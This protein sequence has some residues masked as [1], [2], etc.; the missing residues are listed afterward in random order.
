MGWQHVVLRLNPFLDIDADSRAAT[1][2]TP[3][4]IIADGV[5]P[6]EIKFGELGYAHEAR[7]S[8][9]LFLE[10]RKAG[11]VPRGVRFQ[12]SLP[13]PTAVISTF[14]AARD[15]LAV[16]KAYHKA[17]LRE[18]DEIC[19]AVPHK[20]L[21]IQWDVCQE[22]LTWDGQI[23]AF[24][25]SVKDQNAAI[26][27]RLKRLCQHVPSDVELGLHLCYGDFN[28]RHI[29]EPRDTKKLVELANAVS[30][31][32]A[33]PIG[34]IH[35]PVPVDRDDDAYFRPLGD[36]KLQ[37]GSELYL[38]LVHADGAKSVKAR[39]AAATKYVSSFGIATECG[40]ARARKPHVVRKLLKAHAGIS[41]EPQRKG[42]RA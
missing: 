27:T 7:A 38:G 39:I 37:N 23:A 21:C 20:D 35:M 1:I 6:S 25:I 12:V 42:R 29:V 32:M 8:Y 30:K 13:T 19:A 31:R 28:G 33:R 24:K 41:Q 15:F 18:V 34:Y 9:Q 10:A 26:L 36:L 4:M 2:H 5:R 16:E 14:V 22:M 11:H 17:M 3:L 40:I